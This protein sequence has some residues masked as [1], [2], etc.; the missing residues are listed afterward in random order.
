M[1]IQLLLQ[2]PDELFKSVRTLT[3]T[4]LQTLHLIMPLQNRL[5]PTV[6]GMLL[7]GK[8]RHRCFPDAWLQ[9]GRFAGETKTVI[10]D[11]RSITSYPLLAI[12]EAMDFISK[13][14]L[15]ALEI[16][17]LQHVERWSIPQVAI[18]EALINAFIHIAG[19]IKHIDEIDHDKQAKSQ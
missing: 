8:E 9:V 11:S 5:V 17:N 1:D 3:A 14:S 13:H 10:R 18:R 19:I 15:V 12:Q 6:G 4:D 2:S 7:F 16:K